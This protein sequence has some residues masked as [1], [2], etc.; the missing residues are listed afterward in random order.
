MELK[1]VEGVQKIS[2]EFLDWLFSSITRFGEE[3]FFVCLFLIFYWCVSYNHAF[4]FALFYVVSVLFNSVLKLI[5]KRPRPW[6]ASSAINNKLPAT[7]LSF[8]SGH[9]QS[10]S[11]ISTFVVTDVF[12]SNKSS[13]KIKIASVVVA[14]VL[15]LV[16][17]FSRIY[18][19][20]HYLTD[21]LAGL[22]IGCGVILL[23]EFISKK[24]PDNI[25]QKIKLDFVL[26][27]VLLIALIVLIV[28]GFCKLGLSHT[29][30]LKVFR[31]AGMAIGAILG[32]LLSDRYVLNV[33][34]TKMQKLIK[35]A[36][37]FVITFGVYLLMCLIPI[38]IPFMAAFNVVVS[39][40]IAT[41]VYPLVFNKIITRKKKD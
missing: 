39:A 24:I 32:Y 29:K 8:P 6:M 4:K 2:T 3:I 41:F 7:G 28:V 27:A 17:G 9:S 21:V 10:I 19:G 33:E 12:A 13:K 40:I 16:V 23:L 20:Q 31:Y 15:C 1:I 37:G 35:V 36:V 38:A 26:V 5:V 11:A 34:L 30:V 22:A 18:L 14:T 25:K